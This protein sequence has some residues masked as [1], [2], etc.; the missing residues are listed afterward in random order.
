MTGT[1][2]PTFTCTATGTPTSADTETL[3]PE[4]TLTIT[5]TNTGTATATS[6]CTATGTPT[7]TDTTTVTITYTAEDT[8]TI[9]ETITNTATPTSTCTATATLYPYSGLITV[10]AGTFK[11]TNAGN[12]G[13]EYFSST[14]SGFKMGQY[15]VTYDL[16]YV[17]RQWALANGYSFQNAGLEGNT[18]VIGA[19]PTAA[20]YRPVSSISWRDAIVWSNAYSEKSGLQ[21][22]YT[23]LSAVIRNSTN[24]NAAACDGAVCEWANN[25]YRLPAESEYQYAASWRGTNSGDGAVEFP[26][27]SGNFWTPYN[28]A[29]GATADTTDAAATGL[30]AWYNTNCSGTMDV[31]GKLPNQLG[32]FDMS[33]NIWVWCWD[34]YGSFPVTDKTDYRGP[35]T[36]PNRV[37][38]GGAFCTDESAIKTGARVPY[39]PYDGANYIGFRIARTY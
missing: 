19:A 27:A 37:Q 6:T 4:N 3:T 32:I 14:V 29:S 9:T 35:A 8:K 30:V 36:G 33:G 20:K 31:G 17:V 7:G 24:A 2:E 28:Y 18:G 5:E 34:F 12:P 23:Y 15:L 22:C 10:P 16:W 1:S 26:A 39:G 13:V 21:P 11:Q 38:K 25:G